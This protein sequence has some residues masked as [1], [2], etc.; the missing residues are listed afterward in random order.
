MKMSKLTR[1]W[2]RLLNKKVQMLTKIKKPQLK[3][4]P[5]LTIML[6]IINSFN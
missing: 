5:I 3:E 4:K 6:N 2:G 1:L